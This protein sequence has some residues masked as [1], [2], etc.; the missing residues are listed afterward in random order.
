MERSHDFALVPWRPV[1]K[2]ARDQIVTGRL[3]SLSY[4]QTAE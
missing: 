4:T 1:L 3:S 2:R